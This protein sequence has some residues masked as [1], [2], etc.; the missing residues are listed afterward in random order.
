[1]ENN[2]AESD[3]CV[4]LCVGHLIYEVYETRQNNALKLYLNE[5]I[6]SL[7]IYLHSLCVSV[8]LC[9]FLLLQDV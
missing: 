7:N 3:L 9:V 6:Q 2:A 1:M 4:N 5:I 8:Y